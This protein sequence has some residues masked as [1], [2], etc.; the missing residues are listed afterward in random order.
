MIENRKI[1]Q[2]K[3]DAIPILLSHG[4]P[5]SVVEF[6]DVIRPLA[7]PGDDAAPAFHVVVPSLPGYAFSGK[8]ANPIGPRAMSGY[9]H[10]LMSDV[11][12]YDG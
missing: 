2:F 7:A 4:W 11:L 8:P 9:F 1:L 5:G 3:P 12:G 10:R 6:L